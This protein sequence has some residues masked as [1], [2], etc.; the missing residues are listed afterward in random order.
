MKKRTDF[1]VQFAKNGI[2]VTPMH[3]D[4]SRCAEPA[5]EDVLVFNDIG[6]F[7]CWLERHA[8]GDEEAGVPKFETEHKKLMDPMFHDLPKAFDL[9]E[10]YRRKM[11]AGDFSSVMLSTGGRRVGKSMLHRLGDDFK[12]ALLYGLGGMKIYESKLLPEDK[13]LMVSNPS[14]V[15]CQ[16]LGVDLAVEGADHTTIVPL[17]P[18]PESEIVDELREAEKLIKRFCGAK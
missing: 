5:E 9:P 4:Y 8:E 3:R 7:E 6:E 14:N 2:I 16:I 17:E 13:V 1:S 12:D 11:I 15:P 18:Q 10:D